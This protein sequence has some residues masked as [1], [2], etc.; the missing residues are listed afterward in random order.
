MHWI[1]ASAVAVA[2]LALPT[3]RSAHAQGIDLSIGPQLSLF[4][5][6]AGASLG[7]G[8]SLGF[9][10]EIGF[11]PIGH[12]KL[13]P[14]DSNIDYHSDLNISGG[15]LG[16]QLRPF[17]NNFSLGVGLLVSNYDFDVETDPLTDTVDIGDEEFDGS[18][19]GTL[20][21]TLEH[22]GTWPAVTIGWRGRGFNIGLGVAFSG[23]PDYEVHATGPLANEPVFQAALDREID[24]VRNDFDFSIFPILRIG[25]QF[26][27]IR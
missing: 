14:G 26:G 21:G 22:K 13:D 27:L 15:M 24:D 16:V 1:A 18:S 7:V 11:L 4:G 10:A 9:S 12:V 23:E 2:L 25:Y 19:V 8:R 3:D 20:V 6:G 17:G 5:V